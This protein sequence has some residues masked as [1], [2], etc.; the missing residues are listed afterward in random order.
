MA[1]SNRTRS[2]SARYPS[3][4]ERFWAKVDRRGPDECWPWLAGQNG[5]GYGDFW[6][7]RRLIR[8]H[9]FS[10]EMAHG[11]I[12]DG[13]DSDHTCH[14]RA[15]EQALCAGGTTCPHRACVNPAHIEIVPRRINTLRGIGPTAQQARQTHCKHGH[16][17]DIFNTYIVPS[18]G[19]RLC[20]ACNRNYSG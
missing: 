16:P 17:F 1:N 9:R 15:V 5:Y 12:P 13:M 20:R 7:G 10:Y 8:A 14:N 4:A 19:H 18:T 11:S 2:N 6:N 3:V